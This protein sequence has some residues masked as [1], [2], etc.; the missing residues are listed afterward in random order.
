MS[1]SVADSQ[2]EVL[3]PASYQVEAILVGGNGSASIIMSK[4]STST[5]N[6]NDLDLCQYNYSFVGSTF[7][8]DGVRSKPSAPVSFSADLSGK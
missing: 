1:L 3:D 2:C 4:S 5:V 6:V 8:A 7:T